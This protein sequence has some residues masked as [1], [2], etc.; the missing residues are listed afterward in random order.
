MLLDI[1]LEDPTVIIKPNPNS[2]EYLVIDVGKAI[3]KN[4]RRHNNSRIV[5]NKRQ[6]IAKTFSDAY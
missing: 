4:V 3:L 2:S 1:L 6:D 5:N